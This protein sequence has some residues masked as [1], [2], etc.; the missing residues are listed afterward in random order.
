MQSTREK[1]NRL[2]SCGVVDPLHALSARRGLLDEV[3]QAHHLVSDL[4]PG[5]LVVLAVAL[6]LT[7]A[8]YD[9]SRCS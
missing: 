3:S 5:E 9:L 2:Q 1:L 8:F 7:E 4:L 6:D